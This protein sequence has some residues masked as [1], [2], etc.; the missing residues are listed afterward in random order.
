M[1]RIESTSRRHVLALGLL[2]L[3]VSLGAAACGGGDDAGG[4]DVSLPAEAAAGRE[5]AG[6][7]GCAACHGRDGQGG[8]GPPWVGLAGS[9]VTLEDGSTVIADDAYLTRAITDPAAERVDGYTMQMPGNDLDAAEV[10][11]LVAYI[12][13]LADAGSTASTVTDS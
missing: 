7:E 9:T 13:A 5:L 4:S 6:R 8:V 10:A 3:A 2:S 12:R 11:Q 1:T